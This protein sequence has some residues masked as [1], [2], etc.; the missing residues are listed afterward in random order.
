MSEGS[1]AGSS[2]RLRRQRARRLREEGVW[3]PKFFWPSFATPAT[4]WM[5]ILFVLPF[6]AVLS[7]A[8]G[9]V[10][11][12]FRNPIPVWQPWYWDASQFADVFGKVF[13]GDA[14]FR[15][16]FIRTFVNVAAASALCLLIGYPV[17]Y[18][19]ARF[20]GR[21]KGLYL[22]LLIAPFFI[23]YL[24]RM[25]AWINLLEEDGY[26]NKAFTF[27]HILPEP[28]GWLEGHQLTLVLG[29]V[30]GYIPYMI[31]PLF[32]GLDRI[33]DSLLEAARD[34]GASG[35]RTFVKVTLPLSKPAIMA[36]AVIV[37][38]PMFGDYYTKDLLAKTPSQSMIGNLIDGSVQTPG[39]GAQ[40]AVLVLILSAILLVPMLY[41]LNTTAKETAER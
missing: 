32:A 18:F 12:V 41:Y 22:V 17:A 36:G 3:Y 40:A 30:Y 1:A 34:L 29:L 20:G 38:L 23:S 11:A 39:R 6:Y 25:L 27:L 5:A 26:V 2:R 21:R 19:V 28:Y 7:V 16:A 15:P 33:D 9:T 37:T 14:L 10:D 8:M 4:I 31:L 13:G 24:M 35:V